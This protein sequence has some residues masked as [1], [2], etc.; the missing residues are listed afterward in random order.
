[1]AFPKIH[2]PG[3]RARR[4]SSMNLVRQFVSDV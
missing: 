3:H 1:V 4:C 2:T